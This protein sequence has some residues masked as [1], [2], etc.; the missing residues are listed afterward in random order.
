MLSWHTANN[1]ARLQPSPPV[2]GQPK[3]KQLSPSDTAGHAKR[4]PTPHSLNE[5]SNPVFKAALLQ[6]NQKKRWQTAACCA[7]HK[8]MA[9]DCSRAA[10]KSHPAG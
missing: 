7:R 10:K 3:L 1:T 6:P 8:P 5:P 4:P 2:N 9:V